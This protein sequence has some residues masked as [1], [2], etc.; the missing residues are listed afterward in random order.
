MYS[1]PLPRLKHMVRQL[2]GLSPVESSSSHWRSYF[3]SR[4]WRLSFLSVTP[5]STQMGTPLINSDDGS[6]GPGENQ[7]SDPGAARPTYST[8][9]F[10]KEFRTPS[11]S[12]TMEELKKMAQGLD[13]SEEDLRH[14]QSKEWA[15]SMRP[16]YQWK[17]KL[18]VRRLSTPYTP[19]KVPT[20]A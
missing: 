7:L 13:V 4:G 12:A 11:G 9:P 19:P 15:E 20:H 1:R 14:L 17:T 16:V 3:N 5:H 8:D 6:S 2:T 18:K 10:E